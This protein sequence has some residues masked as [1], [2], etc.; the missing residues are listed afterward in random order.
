MLIGKWEH[1]RGYDQW[2]PATARVRSIGIF[3]V[4]GKF[5]SQAVCEIVWNDQR[6]FQHTGTFKAFEESPLYQLCEGDAVAIRFNPQNPA[7]FY[8]PGL[9]GSDL[10]RMWR[11]SLYGFLMILLVALAF[12]VLFV[13]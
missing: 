3:R 6:D 12:V 1:L 13:W 11:L 9:I 4:G 2:L 7:Q 5:A 8:V 10:T